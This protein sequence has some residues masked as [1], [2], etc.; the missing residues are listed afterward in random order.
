MISSHDIECLAI[1]IDTTS[2]DYANSEK[3]LIKNVYLFAFISVV[4][5]K[6]DNLIL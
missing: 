5:G 1:G 2:V 3:N 6:R 4:D